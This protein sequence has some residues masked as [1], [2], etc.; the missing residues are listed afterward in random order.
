[1]T[2]ARVAL[3]QKRIYIWIRHMAIFF[4]T[5]HTD[6]RETKH[7]FLL[8]FVSSHY[9]QPKNLKRGILFR[10]NQ[11]TKELFMTFSILL[12][13]TTRLFL[14]IMYFILNFNYPELTWFQSN[15]F[16]IF[17]MYAFKKL[18]ILFLYN[19]MICKMIWNN[20]DHLVIEK[21]FRVG[22]EL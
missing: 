11:K 12:F 21:L 1:M 14:L 8:P 5:V 7:P 15:F 3:Y 2:S 16:I 17:L 20:C 13:W 10:E 4:N 18:V 9:S 6:Q 22:I 19:K